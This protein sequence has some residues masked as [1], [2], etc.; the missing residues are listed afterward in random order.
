MN[1]FRCLQRIARWAIPCA[2]IVSM[3]ATTRAQTVLFDFGNDQSFRGLSVHNPDTN[4]NYWNSLRTGVFYQ[5]LIDIQN[6]ATTIDFGFSTPVGTD[7]DNGPA[8][9]TSTATLHD[10]V[11]FTDIDPVALGNLGG[12]LEGPFDYVAGP[13][14]PGNNQVRFEIQQL[15]PAKKY[16]L[17]FF[18]SHAY[19][20]DD[21]TVY[22]VYTDNTYT[23]LVAS[24][25]LDV[26]TPG[27]PNLHNR[28]RVAKL[29]NLSPQTSNILYVQFI[30]SNGSLG[31]LN[32]MQLVGSSPALNGDYNNNG[33]VDGAD[34]VVWRDNVG[35]TNPL[36]NDPTGGTIGP[37]Q[38]N[39]WRSNFGLGAGAG[40]GLGVSAVPE[41]SSLLMAVAIVGFLSQYRRR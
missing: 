24:T 34:Y 5:N 14:I 35:T 40:S 19:S 16:E 18:G 22:S 36:P 41:P 9:P 25:T 6:N 23:T 38:Y 8:G 17:T 3:A 20:N 11:T 10:D 37:T 26:Q 13:D 12:A 33:R 15:D 39:T 30:G 1:V 32:D 28:D 29:S 2:L 27:S 21:T 7:S 31:Y 4:G